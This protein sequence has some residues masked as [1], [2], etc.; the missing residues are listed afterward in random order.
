MSYVIKPIVSILFLKTEILRCWLDKHQDNC[1]NK[2]YPNGKKIFKIYVIGC[3]Q[4]ITLANQSD[5]FLKM[6]ESREIKGD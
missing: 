2:I 5:V 3:F 6:I 1:T 4:Q